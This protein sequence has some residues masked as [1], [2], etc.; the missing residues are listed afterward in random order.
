[1]I[2]KIL[3]LDIGNT[4]I[5]WGVC[6]LAQFNISYQGVAEEMSQLAGELSA[7]SPMPVWVSSVGSKDVNDSVLQWFDENWRQQANFI[8]SE[9]EFKDL[10]NAY[11]VSEDLGVD[12]WL[13]MVA[14]R[15][16]IDDDFCVIDAGTALTIDAVRSTGEHLGGLI[17]PGLSLMAAALSKGTANIDQA[18]GKQHT[19]AGN[20]IDA[21]ASGIMTSWLGGIEKALSEL[22][23][24]LP[25]CTVFVTG[26]DAEKV[27]SININNVVYN[28]D[29]VLLGVGLKARDHYA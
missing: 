20:T 8:N 19:L 25:G 3:C 12:R 21:V 29:L 6:E 18:A 14:A 24:K 16:L 7:L 28:N 4:R 17:M 11:R 9:P 23:Q 13:A 1:M 26:G 2:D 15:N 5:K 22:T 27:K 10:K